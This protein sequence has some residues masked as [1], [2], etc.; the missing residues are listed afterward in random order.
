MREERSFA[1]IGAKRPPWPAKYRTG[2]QR[3]RSAE[4]LRCGAISCVCAY[5]TSSREI[6]TAF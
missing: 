1:A 6:G 5:G 2:R 3:G 4:K